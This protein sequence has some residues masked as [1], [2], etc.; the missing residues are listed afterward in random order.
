M[1][2]EW[3]IVRFEVHGS[4]FTTT[5]VR[6]RRCHICRDDTRLLESCH[7]SV[8]LTGT[9]GNTEGDRS[10]WLRSPAIPG[11]PSPCSTTIQ[12]RLSIGQLLRDVVDPALSGR[13]SLDRGR[14][15]RPVLM[16][17]GWR[18]RHSY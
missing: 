17:R 1:E 7:Q 6:M 12:R 9:A 16:G 10:T 8:Y 2:L 11:S 4:F 18:C 5:A 14:I 15:L 3:A 13:G